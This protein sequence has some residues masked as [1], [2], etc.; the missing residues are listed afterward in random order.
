[1]CALAYLLYTWKFWVSLFAACFVLLISGMVCVV[2]CCRGKKS[3]VT[4]RPLVDRFILSTTLF[5]TRATNG[6][7][8]PQVMFYSRPPTSKN[9]EEEFSSPAV[10]AKAMAPM[11]TK[12]RLGLTTPILPLDPAYQ[13]SQQVNVISCS[14][15]TT[16]VINSNE[17]TLPPGY[18]INRE[19]KYG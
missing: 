18:V 1:M 3:R 13:S 19:V 9:N 15:S 14:T 5:T 11:T 8:E 2:C 16:T 12:D 6:I 4:P 10:V 17:L 7:I